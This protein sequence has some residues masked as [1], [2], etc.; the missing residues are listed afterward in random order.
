M[1]NE[2]PK[3]N[4]VYTIHAFINAVLPDMFIQVN[5]SA[6]VITF[7]NNEDFKEIV[8]NTESG[9]Y[10]GDT[11]MIAEE[12]RMILELGELNEGAK[13]VSRIESMQKKSGGNMNKMVQYAQS[14]AKSI[15]DKHKALARGKAAIDVLGDAGGEVARIFFDKAKELGMDI[16][17]KMY[18]TLKVVAKPMPRSIMQG[19]E[20]AKAKKHDG[21]PSKGN[22]RFSK[23]GGSAI[24]PVGSVN[25][26]TGKCKYFNVYETWDNSTFEIWKTDNGKHRA[27]CTSGIGPI[28]SI[29]SR[30]DFQHDQ[31]QRYLFSA[32]MVDWCQV[33]GMMNL[34]DLYGKSMP[35]YT[36]K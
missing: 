13:D 23:W 36:Y 29:G 7:D 11:E 32:E 27:I 31:T 12:I 33:E 28:Y 35:G 26:I 30:Q 19:K 22:N 4:E 25:F 17:P 10:D 14:M 20:L 5:E 2:F 34:V 21:S 15:K 8:E 9:L 3:T 6:S 24:L 1:F 18:K 16:D